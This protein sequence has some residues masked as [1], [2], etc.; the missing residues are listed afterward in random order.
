MLNV[1]RRRSPGRCL[2]SLTV[3]VSLTVVPLNPARDV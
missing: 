3:L 1:I 2:I